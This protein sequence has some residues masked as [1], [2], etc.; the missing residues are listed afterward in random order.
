MYSSEL[1]V[2]GANFGH[3]I[4]DHGGRYAG[5]I[6]FVPALP[7]HIPAVV[8]DLRPED[9]ATLRACA[10]EPVAAFTE[11]LARSLHA[12]TAL[13]DGE[14]VAM[15]GAA[16]DSFIGAERAHVWLVIS[17]RVDRPAHTVGRG[18][19]AFI[20]AMQ[21]QYGRLTT[22][23]AAGLVGDQWFLAWLGFRRASASDRRIG[24]ALFLG[25]EK[26]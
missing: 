21:G 24:G 14:P 7:A 10:A 3:G 1:P 22:T 2:A 25:F 11:L 9:A 17:G 20:R 19:K 6:E 23:A 4:R 26:G 8:A 5:L 15:W 13:I 16:A 12:G 18:A